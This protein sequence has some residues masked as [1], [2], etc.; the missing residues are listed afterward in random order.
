M[1]RRTFVKTAAVG[2]A[3]A[4]APQL[5]GQAAKSAPKKMV[6]IQIG[7]EV[8]ANADYEKVLDLLQDKACVNTLFA[9]TMVYPGRGTDSRYRGGNSTVM[10]AQYYKDTVLKPDIVENP[11]VR[12]LDVLARLIPAAKKRGMRTFCWVSETHST[13]EHAANPIDNQFW[14]RDVEGRVAGDHPAG[15]CSNNPNYRNFVL[16]LF[17]DY[18]RSYEIDGIMWGVERQGPMSNSL[19]AYH[20]G[21]GSDPNR[22]TCFCQHC[23]ARGKKEGIDAERAKT[24]FRELARYVKAGRAGKRP[25][26]GYYVEFW[27]IL[28]QNPEILQW[29]KLWTESTHEIH[30]GIYK[31]IKSVNPQLQAGWHIWH[32][33]SFNPFF[34]ADEDYQRMTKYSDYVKPVIYYNSAGARMKSYI[35]GMSQNVYGDLPDPES[36][37]FEY[38]VMNYKEGPYDKIAETGF[39]ADYVYRETKRGMDNVAGTKTEIWPGIDIDVPTP[40]GKSKSTPENVRAAVIATMRAGAQGVLL[41]RTYTEMKIENLAGCGNALRELGLV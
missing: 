13:R 24:G 27:R 23:L 17:E 1:K 10:H 31:T 29:H 3:G 2:A 34:R 26:D 12:K 25:I 6:G 38:D 41:S 11:S 33:L 18:A 16:G 22:V 9:K 32:N 15:P 7:L 28:L 37:Q 19:G 35:H 39:S 21:T 36:L 5:L 14:E 8:F 4:L 30:Q 20:D 40:G